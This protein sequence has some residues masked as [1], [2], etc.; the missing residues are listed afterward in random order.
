M[1]D[2]ADA[3]VIGIQDGVLL[4]AAGEALGFGEAGGA[5]AAA[6]RAFGEVRVE[7]L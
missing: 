6:V 7:E 2:R 5:G 4:G 3:L 1:V